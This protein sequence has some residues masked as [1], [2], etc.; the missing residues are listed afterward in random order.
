MMMTMMTMM[1]MVMVMMMMAMA[2][3]CSILVRPAAFG[4]DVVDV[5][6][7]TY[8]SIL[9]HT[10]MCRVKYVQ[11]CVYNILYVYNIQ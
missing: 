3:I 10:E 5:E 1:M 8:I 11:T 2:M 7:C 9:I 4:L 6:T